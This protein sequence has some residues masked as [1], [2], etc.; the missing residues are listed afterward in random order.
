M[1]VNSAD[2]FYSIMG[3][4]TREMLEFG[5]MDAN[6]LIKTIVEIQVSNELPDLRDKYLYNITPWTQAIQTT[7]KKGFRLFYSD[8]DDMDSD[9]DEKMAVTTA[10]G[11][12]ALRKRRGTFR[13]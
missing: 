9:N 3:V 11:M 12:A 7:A 13:L 4:L 1:S 10:Y 8:D 6:Q 5:F 2:E